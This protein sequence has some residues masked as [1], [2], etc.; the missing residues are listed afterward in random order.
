MANHFCSKM[1]SGSG[2]DQ[3]R[4][5]P[6]G[7][8]AALACSLALVAAG[9]AVAQSAPRPATAGDVDAAAGSRWLVQTSVYTKHFHPSP[10][11]VNHQ[12]MVNVEY[13]RADDWLGG[14]AVFNNSFGQPS[15][16][17]YLGR[18]WRPFS[19]QAVH[20]KL[21]GGLLHG[22][23]GEFRDKIPFN[24]SGVAPVLLPSIGYSTRRFTSELILFG[25]NG[26]L[27]TLGVYLN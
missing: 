17:L 18:Q 2:A 10:Q 4:R 27:F 9:G 16:Y 5:C 19:A 14:V 15:Q 26:M 7:A 11:H 12:R 22:Y 6:R 1:R 25:T 20:L 13:Q 24:Q 21:T 3:G 23:K 8:A